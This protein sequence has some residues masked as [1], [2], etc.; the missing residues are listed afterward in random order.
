MPGPAGASRCSPPKGQATPLRSGAGGYGALIKLAPSSDYLYG[1]GGG[2]G[3]AGGGGCGCGCG[4]GAGLPGR[5]PAPLAFTGNESLPV[6]PSC[7]PARTRSTEPGSGILGQL[8]KCVHSRHNLDDG[9][10]KYVHTHEKV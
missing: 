9:H 4:G 7:T 1:G 3:G 6:P 10:E 2:G 5:G 8:G